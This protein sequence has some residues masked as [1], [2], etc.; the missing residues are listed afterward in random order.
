MNWKAINSRDIMDEKNL[1][2]LLN[3][4]KDRLKNAEN[5]SNPHSAVDYRLA[6]SA[7]VNFYNAVLLKSGDKLDI[8]IKEGYNLDKKFFSVSRELPELLEDFEHLIKKVKSIRDHIAH[9]D[10]SVPN[11]RNLKSAINSAEGF[12]DSVKELVTKKISDDKK[13]KTLQEQYNDKTNFIRRLLKSTSTDFRKV[14]AESTEFKKVFKKLLEF[15]KIKVEGLD[16]NSLKSMLVLVDDTI[17]D[18]EKVYEYIHSHCPSCGGKLEI[19]TEEIGHNRGPVDDPEPDYFDIYQ[20]VKCS[21][22]SKIIDREHI[23]RE[24][25]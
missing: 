10:I 21:K 11:K 8:G 20:V 6:A 19:K 2:Y 17:D 18:A 23:T 14:A 24:Y 15:E 5:K 13:G 4:A 7:I 9:S 3:F 1:E 12:N 16:N 22:C 25:V